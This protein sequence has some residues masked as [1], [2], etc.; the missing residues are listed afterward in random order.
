[1]GAEC[2]VGAL[3]C[4]FSL[5]LGATPNSS[6]GSWSSGKELPTKA[7]ARRLAHHDG[8]HPADRPIRRAGHA[9]PQLLGCSGERRGLPATSIRISIRCIPW[10]FERAA[11]LWAIPRTIATV[12]LWRYPLCSA[13]VHRTR[14]TRVR[15]SCALAPVLMAK[16]A[17]IRTELIRARGEPA[18]RGEPPR[19]TFVSS[20]RGGV[21][22][23]EARMGAAKG[24]A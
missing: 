23:S 21:L 18:A 7:L 2:K 16:T 8:V 3:Q 13:I 4:A 10:M 19:A 15:C 1:M 17:S 5:S 9:E 20:S 22:A 11:R 6:E 24:P 14:S 12:S